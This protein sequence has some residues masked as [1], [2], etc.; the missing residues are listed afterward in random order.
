MIFNEWSY[1]ESWIRYM[2]MHY[3]MYLERFFSG[4]VRRMRGNISRIRLTLDA[5]MQSFQATS[6]HAYERGAFR[7][8]FS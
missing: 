7:S 3:G 1:I 2:A 8:P 4:L 6:H 5:L